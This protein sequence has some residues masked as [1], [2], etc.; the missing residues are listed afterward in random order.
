MGHGEQLGWRTEDS[1]EGW[2]G[3]AEQHCGH[4]AKRVPTPQVVEVL[5]SGK[6]TPAQMHPSFTLLPAQGRAAHYCTSGGGKPSQTIGMRTFHDMHGSDG[7]MGPL[8]SPRQPC[9]EPA[10]PTQ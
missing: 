2:L 9:C 8:Q 5:H 3:E 7:Q 6:K 10:H 1:W 4:P